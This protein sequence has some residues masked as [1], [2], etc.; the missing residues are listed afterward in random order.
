[1]VKTLSKHGIIN[2]GIKVRKDLYILRKT[3][4]KAVLLEC[5][6]IDNK[7]DMKKL[8]KT[9]FFQEFCQSIVQGIVKAVSNTI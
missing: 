6:F 7:N 2:R 1:M 5:L 4:S 9:A 8:N 3:S